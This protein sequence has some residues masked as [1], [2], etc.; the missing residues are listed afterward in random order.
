MLA[1]V[2]LPFEFK[3]GTETET[4]KG[5]DHSQHLVCPGLTTYFIHKQ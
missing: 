4:I 2:M 5:F 3:E 1:L